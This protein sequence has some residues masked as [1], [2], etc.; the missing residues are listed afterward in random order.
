MDDF[1]QAVVAAHG[2]YTE[3]AWMALPT[4]AQAQAIYAELRRIDTEHAAAALGT[5]RRRSGLRA[6]PT[7]EI[8][9][10]PRVA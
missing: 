1:Q 2:R 7:T 8:R 5:S 10:M 3:D 4:R 6:V 9:T